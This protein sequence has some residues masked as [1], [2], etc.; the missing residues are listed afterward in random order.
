MD[1]ISKLDDETKERNNIKM[2]ISS[3]EKLS[4]VSRRTT[5]RICNVH[6]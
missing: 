4:R 5:K 1:N 2:S 3:F 6:I